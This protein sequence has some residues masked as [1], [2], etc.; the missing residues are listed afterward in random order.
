MKLIFCPTTILD[1]TGELIVGWANEKYICIYDRCDVEALNSLI[2]VWKSV[3][4]SE[5]FPL[6]KLGTISGQHSDH[7]SFINS[8]K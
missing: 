5:K 4:P 2:D 8:V 7:R 1:G 3:D 6:I